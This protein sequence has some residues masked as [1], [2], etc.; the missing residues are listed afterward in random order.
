ML[1][2][3]SLFFTIIAPGTLTTLVPYLILSSRTRLLPEV[4]DGF[5]YGGTVM[6]AFGLLVYLWCVWEF[7][8]RGQG[9][10]APYDPPKFL[11]A[12]G[13]YQ[14]SRNP[15][16]V[17][18]TSILFGEA[19]FFKSLSLTFY[20]SLV[21]LAFHLRIIYYEEPTLKQLFGEAFITYCQRVPRWI[22]RK[23]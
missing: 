18:V 6:I 20:A 7:I 8:S 22:G 19:L 17:G 11:V 5:N 14:F 2:L 3:K 1:Y 15:M 12:Q 13:L 21:L 4:L 10:P 23:R 16:Y 9:T